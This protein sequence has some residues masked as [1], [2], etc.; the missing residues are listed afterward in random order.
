[1]AYPTA[2]SRLPAGNVFFGVVFFVMLITLGID[3]A[4]A[5]QEAFTAGVLDKWRMSK[6]SVNGIFCVVAFLISIIFTT[7]AGYY[8]QDIADHYI[9]DFG[10]VIVGLAQCVII[11]YVLGTGR[12]R[13]YLNEIS[14]IRL[15]RWWDVMIKVVT[16]VVLV[17]I[18]SV[19]IVREIQNPYGGYPRWALFAGGWGV[20]LGFGVLGLFLYARRPAPG[21]V[22]AVKEDAS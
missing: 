7:H 13:A 22:E 15:G 10:L 3:S 14:E 5:L 12:L 21:A 4:F 19:N 11:G 17:V 6:S 8:W 2:I 18:L 1:M 20:L 16:P 9:A